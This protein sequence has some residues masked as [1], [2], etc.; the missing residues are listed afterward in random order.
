MPRKG[1]PAFN[2]VVIVAFVATLLLAL[3]SPALAANKEGAKCGKVDATVTIANKKL[4]CKKSGSVMRWVVVVPAVGNGSDV[5]W[6]QTNDGWKPSAK[7]PACPSPLRILSPVNLTAVISILYP[8]QYRG[9]NY[10]PHGGFGFDSNLGQAVN[11]VAPLL[12]W[13]CGV[14]DILRAVKYNIRL[15]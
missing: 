1:W 4:I 10:K 15:T 7:P 14:H 11:V 2:R 3:S 5:T 8:G 13:L 6:S 12:E 9:G